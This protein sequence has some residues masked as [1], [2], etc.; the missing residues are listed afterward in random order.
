M[1]F[2]LAAIPTP[3]LVAVPVLLVGGV[4]AYEVYKH[5]Q[6]AAAAALPPVVATAP[7]A[8]P[9]GGTGVAAPTS[10]H[11]HIVILPMHA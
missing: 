1:T 5:R 4:V 3:V 8:P 2:S 9:A 10:G 7:A 11:P 6:A